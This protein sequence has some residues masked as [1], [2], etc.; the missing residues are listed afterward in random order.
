MVIPPQPSLRETVSRPREFRGSP[1]QVLQ[2]IIG[3]LIDHR[4]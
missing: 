1:P 4:G 3:A 2:T